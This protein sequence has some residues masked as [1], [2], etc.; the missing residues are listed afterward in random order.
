MKPDKFATTKVHL[1]CVPLQLKAG[2]VFCQFSNAP[3]GE[4]LSVPVR[5]CCSDGESK[6]SVWKGPVV[7]G[8]NPCFA[9]GP[10]AIFLRVLIL[11]QT[12]DMRVATAVDCKAL[13]HLKDVLVF[14]QNGDRPMSNVRLFRA[15]NTD[16]NRTRRKHLVAIWMVTCILS[17]RGLR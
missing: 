17:A 13:H 14:S 7:I 10:L 4:S 5:S 12:G 1:S 9:T 2:E 16:R 8:K 15:C 11:L 3:Q 6:A